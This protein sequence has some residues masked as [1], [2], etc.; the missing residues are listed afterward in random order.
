MSTM[1]EAVEHVLAARELAEKV[2]DAREEQREVCARVVEYMWPELDNVTFRVRSAF[3]DATPLADT[4]RDL[5]G[6]LVNA[7]RV[8]EQLTQERDEARNARHLLAWDVVTAKEEVE[9]VSS[10]LGAATIRLEEAQAELAAETALSAA[11]QDEL[12]STRTAHAAAVAERD[13]LGVVLGR[14]I[15]W[16][17]RWRM[18]ARV[19]GDS[20]VLEDATTTFAGFTA[21]GGA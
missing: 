9:R 13:G 20:R 7:T 15:P 3:L 16:S 12:N 18:L 19:E 2:A 6:D 11:L 8:A 21:P 1:N 4:I 14:L 5:R 17:E 10:V